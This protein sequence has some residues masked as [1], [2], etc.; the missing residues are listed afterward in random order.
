MF[1]ESKQPDIG[2]SWEGILL[3][4]LLIALDLGQQENDWLHN[5]SGGQDDASASRN[6]D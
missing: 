6:G 1:R 4:E 3:Q 5:T 2:V